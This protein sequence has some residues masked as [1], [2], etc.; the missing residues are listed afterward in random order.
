[1]QDARES[2]SSEKHTLCRA[3]CI[4]HRTLEISTVGVG[5]TGSGSY[6]VVL[7][8]IGAKWPVPPRWGSHHP[9]ITQNRH[10]SCEGTKKNRKGLSLL[11]ASCILTWSARCRGVPTLLRD[12][13]HCDNFHKGGLHTR[14]T[15][16]N[17]CR[18][19]PTCR[20]SG[21]IDPR[22]PFQTRPEALPMSC[23]YE[24]GSASLA[25]I[26]R[27]SSVWI[28]P[29][30]PSFGILILSYSPGRYSSFMS[31]LLSVSSGIGEHCEK[32]QRQLSVQG[33]FHLL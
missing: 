9:I 8:N 26:D 4:S 28:L 19:T 11:L 7:S 13:R 17:F 22:Q 16:G 3:L 5:T 23:K 6:G 14:I 15:R 1:M 20:I 18:L 29:A 31:L 30:P 27:F 24:S 32:R 10:T 21:G 25:P 2:D 33:S 12:S